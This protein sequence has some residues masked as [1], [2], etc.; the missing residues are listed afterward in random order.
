[1][2]S[3]REPSKFHV[4]GNDKNTSDAAIG[5]DY[6]DLHEHR[7]IV[8]RRIRQLPNYEF[9]VRF[10]GAGLS[11]MFSSAVTN[12]IDIL[13][14]QNIHEKY[15]SSPATPNR[16]SFFNVAKG[17][18][19]SEGVLS[20]MN[21]VSA[22]ILRE[23][24]YATIRLGTY[25]A[26][27]DL[28]YELSNGALTREGI[29][30]KALSGLMSGAIGATIANPTDLIKIRM[31]AFHDPPIPEYSSIKSS[32][33]CVYNEGGG[34]LSG[35]L[36]SLWRGTAATV[37]RGAIITVAQI[38]SYDHVKQVIKNH[39]LMNEGMPL[40]L[41]SSLFAGLVCSIASNPVDVVKVRLMNDHERMYHGV[42]DCVIKTLRKEGP[43]AYYKG[44]GMCWIRLGS[45][46]TLT[47]LLYEQLR[48]WAGVK[49]L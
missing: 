5:L 27:K 1:M 21:G 32:L 37:T 15:K 30:L 10:V 28:L 12:P 22:S 29:P 24:I 7:A 6:T 13:R 19:H 33:R 2:Q 23:G 16:S 46:T 25:E 31:Q 38:G 18:L 47:L 9:V 3:S 35:G 17:M 8:P 42:T 11:N 40:H 14:T 41:T 34:T 48:A 20:L 43:L 36:R 26:H 44:F 45:H 39:R 4:L 49:P